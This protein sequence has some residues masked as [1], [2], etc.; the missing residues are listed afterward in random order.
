MRSLDQHGLIFDR[1]ASHPALSIQPDVETPFIAAPIEPRTREKALGAVLPF[2]VHGEALLVK[3][4]E[5][6]RRHVEGRELDHNPLSL[7]ITRWPRA[8][9]SIDGTAYVDYLSELSTYHAAIE[10]APDTEV[11]LKTTDF[12]A[13]A[14]FVLQYV[15]DRL[16]D[17]PMAEATS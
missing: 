4:A 10:A 17:R 9:L 2:P 6:L 1:E 3:L 14:N 16:L 8:R 15:N 7:T 11:I 5:M 13:L 12:D